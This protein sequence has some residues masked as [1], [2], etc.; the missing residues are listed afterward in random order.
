LTCAHNYAWAVI[1][2][3]LIH[4][5]VMIVAI[6]YNI[7]I[8]SIKWDLHTPQLLVQFLKIYFCNW[9]I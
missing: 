7:N 8:K 4:N 3:L 5:E 1:F 6:A 9:G 2:W